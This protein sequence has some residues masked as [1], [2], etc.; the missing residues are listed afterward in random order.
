MFLPLNTFENICVCFLLLMIYSTIGWVAEMIYHSIVIGHMSEKRGFLNGFLCP[1]YGHG[2]LLVLYVL[3]GGLKNPILT[4]LAG[5]VLTSALEYFTS[6]IMEVL[7]HMRWWDY[8]NCKYQLNGRVCLTNTF[9]FG[10]GS[11]LLCPVVNPPIMAWLF[12]VGPAYTIPAASFISG[13]YLMDITLSVRSAIQLSNRLDKL[14]QLRQEVKEHLSQAAAQL[15]QQYEERL[16]ERTDNF[17]NGLEDAYDDF[18]RERK[19]RLAQ[20]K[21]SAD[22]FERRLLRSHPGLR[23]KRGGK[24]LNLLREKRPGGKKNGGNPP[25]A[26]AQ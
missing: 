1:I 9:F 15:Q 6:W 5:M 24:L 19:L 3:H 2:A 26:N 21:G 4:F 17:M 11:V 18:M 16:E 13:L 20:L 25:A 22:F 10:L 7:F 23:P 12:R 8:S 14:H